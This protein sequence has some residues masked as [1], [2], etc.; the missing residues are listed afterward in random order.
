MK[1]TKILLVL[2]LFAP[3]AAQADEWTKIDTAVEG[4]FILA[5]GADYFT[6]REMLYHR[7]F[8]ET[9]VILG[10]HP[11]PARLTTYAITCIVT[12]AVTA[13]LLP[14]PYRRIFQTVTIGFEVAVATGNVRTMGW[15]MRGKF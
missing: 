9:N 1:T 14:N 6:T 8:S 13:R 11:S 12:H 5:I 7:G 4:A 2:A 10:E 3:A 15:S